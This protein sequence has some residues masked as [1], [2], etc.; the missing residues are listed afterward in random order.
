[1]SPRGH[2]RGELRELKRESA[3]TVVALRA[4]SRGGSRMTETR[5]PGRH[6]I[7]AC[8]TR[9]AARACPAIAVILVACVCAALGAADERQVSPIPVQNS[10]PFTISNDEVMRILEDRIDHMHKG[11]GLVV[12]LID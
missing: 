10:E 4:A 1:M 11:V 2:G 3:G 7:K 9:H 8:P 12:G 6:A 5:A